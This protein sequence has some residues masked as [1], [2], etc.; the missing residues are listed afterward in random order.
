M[1]FSSR[2]EEEWAEEMIHEKLT[3]PAKTRLIKIIGE[4]FYDEERKNAFSQARRKEPGDP[5]KEHP[6][7]A[8]NKRKMREFFFQEKDEILFAYLEYLLFEADRNRDFRGRQSDLRKAIREMEVVLESEGVLWDLYEDEHGN[9]RFRKLSSGEFKEVDEKLRGLGS[10]Q[11]NDALKPYRKAMSQY[12]DG[13]YSFHI[14][15][16]LNVSVE[17]VIKRICKE[18]GWA[19]DM[20][21]SSGFYIDKMKENGFFDDNIMEQELN[22]LL[23]YLDLNRSKMEGQR[24]RHQDVKRN[25]STLVLHQTAA[26]LYYLITRFENNNY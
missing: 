21:R 10:K 19:S 1:F 4:S 23:K 20:D 16:K 12:A 5:F 25:Y 6:N 3:D 15:E 17:E 11:W 7:I 26:Y 18:E 8:S 22:H 14:F 13:E 2:A 9:W 24:K